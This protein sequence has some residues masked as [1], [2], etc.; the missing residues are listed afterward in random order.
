MISIN[1]FEISITRGDS[2]YISF[3]LK[4]KLGQNYALSAR[5]VIKCQVR[6]QVDG[7]LLFEGRIERDGDDIT[8]HIYPEDTK[9]LSIDTYYWDAEVRLSNGD[10]YSFVPV[11][12]FI[13]L[14]EITIDEE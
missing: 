4:N 6:D 8:W 7:N 14:P 5:D 9:D 11:S 13:I 3:D 2:G 1:K 10:I 12:K